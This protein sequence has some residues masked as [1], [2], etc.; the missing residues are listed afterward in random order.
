MVLPISSKSGT[1]VVIWG[2]S[3]EPKWWNN[4]SGKF[5]SVLFTIPQ[6]QKVKTKDGEKEFTYFHKCKAFGYVADELEKAGLCKGAHV[7]LIGELKTEKWNESDVTIVSVGTIMDVQTPGDRA[8]A[9]KPDK[10]VSSAK[11]D[12]IFDTEDEEDDLP[13]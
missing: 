2:Y 8:A 12:E 10:V 5:K 13:F 6:T 7:K 3:T 1:L 11:L 9:T 4:E